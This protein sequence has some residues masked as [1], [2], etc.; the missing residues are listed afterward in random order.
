MDEIARRERALLAVLVVEDEP[1]VAWV[2]RRI[3]EQ[4]GYATLLAGSLGEARTALGQERFDVVIC[5]ASL[6]DGDGGAFVRELHASTGIAAVMMS[7]N[8]GML[9]GEG[10]VALSKPFTPDRLTLALATALGC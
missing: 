2:V 10:I 9:E 5:D 7:G 4:S 3:L 6:P 8:P 1:R